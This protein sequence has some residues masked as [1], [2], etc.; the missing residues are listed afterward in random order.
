MLYFGTM[1]NEMPSNVFV[2]LKSASE[3]LLSE[4]RWIINVSTCDMKP[5]SAI[6]AT[7]LLLILKLT[8]SQ[9]SSLIVLRAFTSM[10]EEAAVCRLKSYNLFP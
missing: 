8:I 7:K 1:G 5:R 9:V 3:F 6:K 2:L 10:N 4:Y